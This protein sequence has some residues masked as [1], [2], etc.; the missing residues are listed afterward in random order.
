MTPWLAIW[1]AYWGRLNEPSSYWA[2]PEGASKNQLSH[3]AIGLWLSGTL[4]LFYAFQFGEMPSRLFVW[5]L[6]TIGYFI[7]IEWTK[8]GWQGPD[9]V[10]D[11][12]FFSLGAAVP[13]VPLKEASFYPEIQLVLRERE[14]LALMLGTAVLYALHIAPRA[15]RWW[16][17]G[18]KVS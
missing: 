17:N 11:T 1:Q 2:D 13:L 4:C 12:M 15:R 9:S 8:Q 14:G 7:L 18:R 16:Y 6:L 10:I 3:W 5:S